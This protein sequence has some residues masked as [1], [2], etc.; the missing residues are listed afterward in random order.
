MVITETKLQGAF[1]IELELF[2]DTRGFFA[3]A[4]SDREFE[5]FGLN[6]RFVESNISFNE[7]RGTLRGMHY[8][9][10]PYDQTKLVRCTRGSIYDVIIDL[11]PASATF[12][13]WFP[14][15]LSA[16][17][18]RMLYVPGEFAHGY[19]TLED[20]TEVCYQTAAYYA[21]EHG[22]GVRWNDPAF[23]ITWPGEDLIIIERDRNYPDFVS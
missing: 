2:T 13:Q 19:Q 23:N 1:V 21:P 7:K 12:K 4:W 5:S 9:L 15:E 22:R 3:R 16:E 20:S 10:P 11:R 14:I 17:N 18:H 8:Q 6:A